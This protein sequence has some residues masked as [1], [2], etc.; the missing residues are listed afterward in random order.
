MS[1]VA[2]ILAKVAV[3]LVTAVLGFVVATVVVSALGNHGPESTAIAAP[4]Y[5]LNGPDTPAGPG[6]PVAFDEQPS[7][8][9]SPLASLSPDDLSA[10][11]DALLGDAPGGVQPAAYVKPAGFPRIPPITQFDGGPFQGANCTLASGAMLARLGYGIV[12][13]GSILRT[14]Q[15][16][17]DGGTGIDDL[18]TA[19]WRGYGITF[20][21]GLIRTDALK[22][23]L[24]AGYGAV[25][26]GVYAKVPPALRLQKDFTGGHAIYLD[27]Y[28]P[29][30]AKRGIPE[31]YYVIDP[32]GRPKYG[33]QGDW[34]PAS[35]VD[36]F[37]LA[38]GGGRVVAMWGYPPGGTPPDVVGPDV[39]PIPPDSNGGGSTP[40]PAPPSGSPPP[41]QSAAP[42]AS[43]AGPVLVPV[44]VGDISVVLPSESPPVDDS[45]L[46]GVILIPIIDVCLLDPPPAGCPTGIEAVF[47]LGLP[48][49]IQPTPAPAVNV[50][51]VD[52]DR[53]DLAMVGF[54]VDPPATADVR[55]WK[56]GASPASVGTASSMTSID[57]FGTTVLLA[58]LD[59][60]AATTYQFQA[61]AG[62][63]AGVGSSPIGSFTTGDGVTQFDVALSSVAS[64][65]IQL[66]S[67]LSPY[68]HLAPG[69]Y[70]QP[71]VPIDSLGAATCLEQAGFGGTQFC[72][73]LGAG[74]PPPATCTRAQVTYQLAGIDASGVVVRAFPGDAGEGSGGVTLDGV[75]EADGPAPGGDVSVGCLTPGMTYQIV[76]DAVG[77]D[78]GILAARSV[79]VP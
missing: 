58:R 17:Q 43:P 3:F 7:G 5:L 46:G 29:G 4:Q 65:P 21:H 63:G 15:D 66:G 55:F 52:S 9:P 45:H 56:S 75:L 16:D 11:A 67:G 27:G 73:D 2:S 36:A 69:G 24:A 76:L 14:Q 77:D 10:A 26:Q 28:Y 70:A 33:Y 42:S 64:P 72:L 47:D 31:A 79:T 23:L 57:L 78:R 35:V 61:V 6:V 37:A 20:P 32:I 68:L 40:T 44:D 8:D 1:A 71:L 22:K 62:S 25:V 59:V 54:T 38:W 74:A 53:P 18:A 49:Q 48:P 30:N 19:L 13:T 60:Q 39:L 12:T 34:W 50:L 51:F 41:S